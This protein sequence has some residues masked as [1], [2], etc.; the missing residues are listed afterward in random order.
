MKLCGCGELL[1][2]VGRGEY[3]CSRCNSFTTFLEHKQW[4]RKVTCKRCEQDKDCKYW[5]VF[6]YNVQRYKCRECGYEFTLQQKTRRAQEDRDKEKAKVIELH[7]QGL[8]YRAIAEKMGVSL[9]WVHKL[10]NG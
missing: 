7:S 6:D 8:T 1:A 10:I 9:G 5:G 2:R 3:E 4:R